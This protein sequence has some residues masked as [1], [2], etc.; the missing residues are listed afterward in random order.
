M[1]KI[2]ILDFSTAEVFIFPYDENIYDNA[3]DFFESAYCEEK[4]IRETN[5]Q[6]MV[7]DDLKLQI[8]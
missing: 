5:C 4:G 3:E 2:I 6:Y 1:K 8:Y 7:T